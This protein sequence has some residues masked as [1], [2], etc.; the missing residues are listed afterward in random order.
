MDSHKT[1]LPAGAENRMHEGSVEA[2]EKKIAMLESRA[3]IAEQKA[4]AL[5]TALESARAG[6]WEWNIENG[7]ILIDRQW[8]GISGYNSAEFDMLTMEQW[9]ELCHPADLDVVTKS[10]EEL[11]DGSMEYLELELRVRHK[12]GEW[13]RVLDC[14]K[15]TGRSQNGKPSCL[16]GSRQALTSLHDKA[17]SPIKNAPEKLH[18]LIDNIPGAIYHIDVSGQATVRFQPPA[19]LKTLVSEHAGT[20]RLNTLS[21]IHHDDRHMLSNA[22]S[23]LRETKHSLTLVYRIV[24]PEGKLHWI[25]DH[26]SSSFSDD[27]L[28]SGIDGIL[29]EVTDRIARLEKICKLESQLSKSQRLETI[30]TLAGGIAHDFNNIL[31][32]ILGYAEMGLSGVNEDDPMHEYFAEIMQAAERAQ[33]LVSQILTFS[34]AEEGKAAP[35]SIQEVIDEVIR[36]MRP[37]LPST[38]SIEEDIDS[39]CHK[40]IADPTQMHQVVVNLCTNALHAMEQTGGVLKIVLREV[41][42]GNGRPPIVPE[43]PDGNY[44]ELIISDTGTGMDDRAIERIFEPFFTT[45]SVEKGSGLGLSVVHGIV[46][47]T[48][49]HISVESAQGKG[50]AFHV[51]LPVIKSNTPDRSKQ[52]PLLAKYAASVLFID[53]EPATVNLVTI[54]M[55]KLGYNIRAENSPVEALKLFREQPDLFDLVITDLT[56]P[57]MTG[58]Q[59]T[60]EIHKIVPS[61]PVILMTG[62]GKMIDHD[63]PLKHY[64]IN[65][66]LK[67]PLKLAHLALAVKEVLSSTTNLLTEI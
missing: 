52:N 51:W 62:Y 2:L 21:M 35:V 37:S 44:A 48:N 36:L 67:K 27:G 28:F 53:D 23:K 66:L 46:T 5:K 41:S 26:M 63:M 4:E 29:C 38:V 9:R 65:R 18:A 55:T 33:K 32:P 34:K 19:F 30:G 1:D 43:L 17:E 61:I 22:Y 13:I 54:M 24:A 8:A 16:T 42:T 58:I 56:M 60:S 15:I 10:I 12:N 59:L 6:Y 31:T 11:L 45:K 64:G 3:S 40:V 25:E 7:T 39:S 57:E 20:A 14:G 47:G 49:G 50:S